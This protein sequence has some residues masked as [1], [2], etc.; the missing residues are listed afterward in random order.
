MTRSFLH[1]A[2]IHLDSPLQ[3]LARYEHAPAERIRTATRRAFERMIDLALEH[4]VDFVLIAGDL[5]D[6]TWRDFNSGL[7]LIGELG[8]LR[9]ANIRVILIAGNHDAANKMTRTLRLP[10]TV[11]FLSHARPETV[12]LDEI[13]VAIHGQSFA[14]EA[15]TENLA[16]A[17]PTAVPGQFNIGVLHTGLTGLEGHERYAPCTLDDL[18]SRGYDYWALGHI[19]TRTMPCLD[20]VVA[21]PGNTQGRHI[22]ETGEKGCLLTTIGPNG[23]VDAVFHRLDV[24]RWERARV[25][26]G[27]LATE[28]E[29]FDRVA[30]GLDAQL[31]AEPDPDRLLAV[32]V[33]IHGAAPLHDRLHAAAERITAEVRSLAIERGGDR[34]WVEKVEFQTRRPRSVS[35][36][37]GP[38]EELRDVLEELRSDPAALAA[39]GEEL[40]ELKRK[41]GK[42]LMDGPDAPRMGDPDWMSGLLEGIE[43]LLLDLLL[44]GERGGGS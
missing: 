40:G 20:P 12:R 37:D 9:D 38:L 44:H 42:E 35:L 3:G 23:S 13:E 41:L 43:P 26:A 5:F 1:A 32:R 6:N 29:L 2:D 24:V 10:P 17:Y 25:D 39:L 30:A 33:V 31:Q 27:G 22:R 36:P 18:R 11:Q 7:Y 14:R 28:S 19:H 4:R 8:R 16:A 21:F 15:V 34:L